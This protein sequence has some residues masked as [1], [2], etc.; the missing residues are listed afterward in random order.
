MD[1]AC[2][3]G[4]TGIAI[5]GRVSDDVDKVVRARCCCRCAT[6]TE[7]ILEPDDG[8]GDDEGDEEKTAT[9]ANKTFW[10]LLTAWVLN[11]R[12]LTHTVETHKSHTDQWRFKKNVFGILPI[13]THIRFLG[14]TTVGLLVYPHRKEGKEEKRIQERADQLN[15]IDRSIDGKTTWLISWANVLLFILG[16]FAENANFLFESEKMKSCQLAV[17]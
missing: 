6:H 14:Y 10:N 16:S 2:V 1:S 12:T 9:L 13:S 17:G 15:L 4:W 11:G 7:L 5:S 3:P 8:G